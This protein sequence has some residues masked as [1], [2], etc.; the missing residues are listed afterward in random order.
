MDGHLLRH[1]DVGRHQQRRPDDG[2]EL[3]DVLADQVDRR[4]PELLG[5][6]LP[7]A[8]VG[9]RRVVVEERVD[10]D[11]DHLRLV[12]RHRHSPLQ[13]RAG[14]RDVAQAALDERERLVVA[15]LRRDEAGPLGVE[16]L[17]R[18]L[19]G[20]HPEEPVV[21]LLSLEHDLVDRAAIAVLDLGVGL[22]VGAA[23]AVPALV[24]AGVDVA[25]VVDP[26]HHLGDLRHVLRIRRADEEV[27]GGVEPGGELLEADRV[28]V[29]ELARRDPEPLGLLRDGLAVLV[30]AGEEEDVLATLAHVPRE[31]VGGDGRVGVPEMGLAV[32]VV[33]RRGHVVRHPPSMLPAGR[34]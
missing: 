5:E 32:H 23:G 31:H 3:E 13:A 16:L 29:A 20:G 18:L 34:R 17:E 24:G 4:R 30:R 22:E 8:G 15:V 27:V 33:D 14:E 9:Q 10:P 7:R 1:L 12:P 2:V 28:P 6:V 19:E 26:L 21:L 11:V 25:V